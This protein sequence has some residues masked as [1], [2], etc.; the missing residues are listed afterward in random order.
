MKK[1]F[2]K[3]KNRQKLIIRTEFYDKIAITTG[4]KTLY[5]SSELAKTSDELLTFNNVEASF[6]ICRLNKDTVGISA[7]S[8][9]GMDVQKIMAHFNG[10]GHKT[11][12]A[13][14]INGTDVELVKEELINYIRGI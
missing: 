7:R 11:D 4:G 6:T 10:G 9:G 13:A 5:D 12:A 2:N 3:Y 1:N 8:L 14:Q